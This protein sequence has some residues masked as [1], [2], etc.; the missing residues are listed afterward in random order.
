MRTNIKADF[1]L[2]ISILIAMFIRMAHV[3]IWGYSER[4][5]LLLLVKQYYF[6]ALAN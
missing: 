5:I 6:P 2:S 1:Q 3:P 4:K